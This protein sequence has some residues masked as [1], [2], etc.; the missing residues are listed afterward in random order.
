M[1]TKFKC[2]GAAVG[3]SWAHVLGDAFSAAEYLN[4]LGRVVAGFRPERPLNLGHTLT[5][6]INSDRL[7]KF[8][9]EPLSIKRVD[10]VGDNWVHVTKSKMEAFSFDVT[11]INLSRL[12]SRMST[13]GTQFTPFEAISAVVW[14][15]IAKIRAEELEPRAVTICIGGEQNKMTHGKSNLRNSQVVSTVEADFPIVE[16]DTSELAA[17]VRDEAVDERRMIEEAI[18]RDRG[19]GDFI[20]YGANLTFVNLEEA[21][22]YDFEYRGQKPVR[23]SYRVDGVG[24]KGVVLVLPGHRGGEGRSVVAI[25][26]ENEICGLKSELKREGLMA[27]A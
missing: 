21:R 23:V 22:F 17:L 11:P 5:K 18:D 6:P 14:Q 2:G 19:L 15:C 8:V 3:L 7:P 20:I 26:P 27:A 25:M 16:A 13:N 9:E 1:L 4:S 10:P 24:E 12:R